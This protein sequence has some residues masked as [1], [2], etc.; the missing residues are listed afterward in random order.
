VGRKRLCK[1]ERELEGDR[2]RKSISPRGI[3]DEGSLNSKPE[4]GKKICQQPKE[5]TRKACCNLRCVCVCV[6]VC[7]GLH[8]NKRLIA[9]MCVCAC[10]HGPG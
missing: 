3:A 10:V 5:R 9:F 1:R 6:C 8:S 2:E 7:V 4:T